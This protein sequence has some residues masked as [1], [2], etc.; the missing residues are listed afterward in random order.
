MMPHPFNDLLDNSFTNQF[1][2]LGNRLFIKLRY[3]TITAQIMSS[4]ILSK[5][6]ECIIND[7]FPYAFHF[8]RIIAEML[9]HIIIEYCIMNTIL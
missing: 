3:K 6:I 1:V 2:F 8:Y 5:M 7:I 9:E 4:V